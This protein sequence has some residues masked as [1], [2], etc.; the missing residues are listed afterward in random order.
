VVVDE[1]VV[2]GEGAVVV[3]ID[4]G[5]IGVVGVEAGGNGVVNDVVDEVDDEDPEGQ[6]LSQGLPEDAVVLVADG[7]A[8]GVA[9]GVVVVQVP[10]A[11]V[12]R[13]EEIE[14]VGAVE[15]GTETKRK[16]ELHYFAQRA[17]EGKGDEL[18]RKAH[19]GRVAI[20]KP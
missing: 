4:V 3:G 7:V 5:A 20:D 17:Y 9:I 10:E 1:G 18:L 15:V 8:D 2:D 19:K 13:V 16:Q 12:V 6:E 14:V 11:D